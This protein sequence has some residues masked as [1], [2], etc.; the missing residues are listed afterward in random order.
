LPAERPRMIVIDPAGGL[1]GDM[2]LG[3]LLA[4]GADRREV[5]RLV[6]TLPGLDPFRIVLGRVR[7]RGLKAVRVRVEFSES[8]HHRDLASI[9][10]MIER[11]R[12][13]AAVKEDASRTFRILGEAEGKVHGVPPEKVHFHEVGAVDSIVDIVGS[14]C[15]LSLLGFPEL[16]HRTPVLGSGSVTFSHGTLPLPAPATL[17]VLRGRRVVMGEADGEVVTPTGAALAVSLAGEM[18]P[19]MKVTPDR[20]VYAAGTRED[21]EPGMLRALSC[22]TGPSRADVETGEV[23]VL[24]TTVDDMTPEISGHVQALLLSEGALEVYITPVQMK[25]CRPGIELTVLCGEDDAERLAGT[26]FEET[27][28]IGIRTSTEGRLELARS[29]SKVATPYG[30]VDVKHA[31]LP[32]GGVK[33]APEYESCREA[34]GRHSVPVRKVFEAAVAAT[35]GQGPGDRRRKRGRR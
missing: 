17:E 25:K 11:S 10:S 5:E 13:D 22:L 34:A 14:V 7:R 9:L 1:S 15:A 26:V 24:K 20:I 4:L 35:L 16:Y 18:P 2:F 31:A 12:L 8:R 3:C 29:W 19:G 23:T 21:G 33:S 6:S 30:E 27:T 32:G 28:T